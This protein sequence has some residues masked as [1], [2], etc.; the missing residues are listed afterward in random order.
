MNL[1]THCLFRPSQSSL[2]R[3]TCM[4]SV[5]SNQIRQPQAMKNGLQA[6]PINLS[7]WK[8]GTMHSPTLTFVTESGGSHSPNSTLR[9]ETVSFSDFIVSLKRRLGFCL[10]VCLNQA[11]M[12]GKLQTVLRGERG[13]GEQTAKCRLSGE[14]YLRTV[15]YTTRAGLGFHKHVRVHLKK[16]KKVVGLGA[17]SS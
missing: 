11:W 5:Q 8:K 13:V 4:A 2:T 10:F 6:H 12:F 3:E 17:L 7:E 14:F 15:F 16:K 9:T 1:R